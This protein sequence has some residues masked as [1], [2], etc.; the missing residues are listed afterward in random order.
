MISFE[1]LNEGKWRAV[2]DLGVPQKNPKKKQVSR[3]EYE[4]SWCIL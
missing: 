3:R 2:I 4:G 1:P